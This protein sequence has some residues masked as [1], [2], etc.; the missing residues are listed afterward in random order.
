[1]K[2]IT[3]LFLFTLLCKFIIAQPVYTK[4]YTA[5][6]TGTFYNCIKVDT[7]FF[8][9]G[10]DRPPQ[11]GLLAR[12]NS[13]GEMQWSN[14]YRYGASDAFIFS[15]ILVDHDKNLVFAVRP[16]YPSRGSIVKTDQNGTILW[17]QQLNY[18]S[19]KILM[20]PDSNYM[21]FGQRNVAASSSDWD[22]YMTKFDRQGNILFSFHYVAPP[23]PINFNNLDKL[24]LDACIGVDGNYYVLTDVGSDVYLYKILPNGT[25]ISATR[26]F[27]IAMNQV[28]VNRPYTW[29]M[30]NMPDSTFIVTGSDNSTVN[31][32][33]AAKIDMNGNVLWNKKYISDNIYNLGMTNSFV[34]SNGNLTLFSYEYRGI[35]LGFDNV[36]L[37][38]ST[39]GSLISTSSFKYSDSTYYPLSLNINDD[40]THNFLS[41]SSSDTNGIGTIRNTYF[42]QNMFSPCITDSL[43][44]FTEQDFQ[45]PSPTLIN[46][47]TTSISVTEANTSVVFSRTFT[48][49]GY[50]FST[51]TNSG[52]SSLIDWA[53]GPNPVTDKLNI[54]FDQ[55]QSDQ[56]NIKIRN[57]F[58]QI[59]FSIKKEIQD[60]GLEINLDKYNFPSGIYFVEIVIDN[61]RSI[62]KIIKI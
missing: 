36:V 1:M 22:L 53:V 31:Y 41:V 49:N 25:A 39:N 35:S 57:S 33:V 21:V 45:P 27:D 15:S 12:L 6:F 60:S 58:G 13:N 46:L 24:V 30:F 38:I 43:R 2:K 16:D 55:F 56:A 28:Y 32:L 52:L 29:K 14:G 48:N 59:I 18:C 7:S 17:Y 4:E 26:Y 11:W 51:E 62:K 42:D 44:N 40:F 8:I 50:C 37:K 20:A 19:I 23:F 10:G 3:T 54:K 9:F 34:E 5:G 47:S 61:S